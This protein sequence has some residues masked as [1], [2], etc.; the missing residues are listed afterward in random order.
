MGHL[1]SGWVWIYHTTWTLDYMLYGARIRLTCWAGGSIV[2]LAM[3]SRCYGQGTVTDKLGLSIEVTAWVS[4]CHGTRI[5]P[6]G[7]DIFSIQR[8]TAKKFENTKNPALNPL[9]N[10]SLARCP[11]RLEQTLGCC[12]CGLLSF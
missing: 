4:C 6:A 7:S 1:V 11:E 9:F 12:F 8:K 2:A 5:Q 10:S 3:D